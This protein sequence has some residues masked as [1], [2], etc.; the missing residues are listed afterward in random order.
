MLGKSLRQYFDRCVTLYNEFVKQSSEDGRQS[1]GIAASSTNNA[2]G[3]KSVTS[4]LKDCYYD[5]NEWYT[6]SKNEKD[7]VLKAHSN[8][9]GGKKSTKSGLQ[10]NSGGG[11]KNG[12]VKR[13]SKITMLEKKVRNQKRHILV[14]NTA[15]KPGSDDEES[16]GSEKEDVNRKH[17][18]LTG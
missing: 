13:K 3:N 2:I 18:S 7:K 17:S 16:D 10:H 15:A 8:R 5:S 6:L 12:H 9:N 11:S 4:P 14:F 1:L